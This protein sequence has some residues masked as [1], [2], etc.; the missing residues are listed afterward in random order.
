MA[1]GFLNGSAGPNQPAWATPAPT[2]TTPFVKV[3]GLVSTACVN[4]GD[5]TYLEM[6]V[7]A[8][9]GRRPHGRTRRRDHAGYGAGPELGA[10]T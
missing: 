9:S 7:T 2:I 4:K 8:R 3:P 5:Y 6:T 10:C 1:K